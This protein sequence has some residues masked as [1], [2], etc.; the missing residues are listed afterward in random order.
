[1]KKLCDC[2]ADCG[3]D[4]RLRVGKVRPCEA[5]RRQIVTRQT[6]DVIRVSRGAGPKEVVVVF[7]Q[8][9]DDEQLAVFRYNQG[10]QG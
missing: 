8:P 6:P 3:D 4:P 2:T 5:R 7:K 9:L 1:M 10:I